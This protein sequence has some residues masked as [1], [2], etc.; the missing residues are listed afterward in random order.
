MK[1]CST[2]N[3]RR[4]PSIVS[5][6]IASGYSNCQLS[7]NFSRPHYLLGMHLVLSDKPQYARGLAIRKSDLILAICDVRADNYYQRRLGSMA[8]AYRIPWEKWT[9]AALIVAPF[10]AP[11][12]LFGQGFSSGPTQ[13]S[14]T[15]SA[16]PSRI[17]YW[18][19][20]QFNI[21]FDISTFGTAP[22]EVHLEVSADGGRSYRIAQVAT[23]VDREFKFDAMQDGLYLFRLV[24]VD[25]QGRTQP[26]PEPPMSIIVDTEKPKSEMSVDIDDR[27]QLVADF[28][29]RETNFAAD[30]VRLEYRLEEDNQWTSSPVQ[31]SDGQ[32]AFEVRGR[33][34]FDV[35]PTAHRVL[36]R[37]RVYDQADN[38]CEVMRFS[39]LPRTAMLS[40]G[41]QLASQPLT[42]NNAAQGPSFTTNSSQPSPPRPAYNPNAFAPTTNQPLAASQP[43]NA[44]PAAPI[45]SPR[46]TAPVRSQTTRTQLAPP[47][48]DSRSFP[49][50]TS[51]SPFSSPSPSPSPSPT[52]TPTP[53]NPDSRLPAQPGYRSIASDANTGG[54]QLF[55]SDRSTAEEVM[56]IPT[57]RPAGEPQGGFGLAPL[58]ARTFVD[59][60][61]PNGQ[62][63]SQSTSNSEG[64]P[65]E[66]QARREPLTSA[67]PVVRREAFQSKTRTFALDYNLDVSPRVPIA[68]IQLFA[69]IDGG[70]TWEKW[71]V[72]PDRRSPFEIQVQEDGLFGFRMVIVDSQRHAS[73]I[74][75]DGD[76]ADVW[77]YVDT[78]VPTAR[79]QSALY[80]E[81]DEQGKLIIQYD[82][83]DDNLSDRPVTISYSVSPD[84]PWDT[85]G[86]NL[87][88]NGRFAWQTA[89]DLP[90]QIFLRIQASDI[91]GNL[92]T[93]RFP[94]AVN[95]EGL[96][97]RGRIQGF[98]PLNDG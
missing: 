78:L 72:D 62:N 4:R 23:S 43:S 98:R 8:M 33:S 2:G 74:P 6:Q 66:I 20:R 38:E 54:I 5:C 92:T 60:P 12:M 65:E 9:T 88:N 13:S 95:I 91:A 64:Q 44:N 30:K 17:F 90:R 40:G 71:G 34:V 59:A 46:P 96:T 11:G 25:Q 75:R 93:Y 52:P 28:L 63:R 22:A 61:N 26:D 94:Q 55:G 68:E 89:P 86:A 53:L 29:I 85:A 51:S 14:P 16:E 97:P 57:N 37:L 42:R 82:V 24:L 48:A 69:T 77:V 18:G 15:T 39:Q 31:L 1:N 50:R 47:T 79:I 83:N 3:G 19:D 76:E 35:P 10:A 45:P 27:G 67:P 32:A 87:L 21:P 58:D 41:L 84:G 81:G 7:K 80:G 49:P 70:Q 73:N 56:A 36:V